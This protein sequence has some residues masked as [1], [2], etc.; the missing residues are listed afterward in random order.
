MRTNLRRKIQTLCAGYLAGPI[1][2]VLASRPGT[3]RWLNRLYGLLT[4]RE[5]RLFHWCFAK[6]F[7]GTERRLEKGEWIVSFVGQ[8]I[9]IPLRGESAWLDWDIAVSMV[10]HDTEIVSTYESL[11][12]ST[13]PP[14][15]FFDIGAN[16]GMHSLLLLAHNVETVSFEPNPHCHGFFERL[17]E[18]NNV[19]CHIEPMALGAWEGSVDLWFPERDTWLGTTV[20]EEAPAA[21]EPLTRLSVSQIT[22]DG[23]VSACGRAPDLI[24]I[25]TEGNEAQILAG[26]RRTLENDRPWVIF[27]SRRGSDRRDLARLFREA[28]YRI[29]SLPILS[30]RRK[31]VLGSA[32]FLDHNTQNFAAIPC[33][34]L[35]A[36]S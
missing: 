24:K 13:R 20:K 8:D 18:Y 36:T 31:T 3:R 22:L 10:G 4:S 30:L 9:R 21:P 34:E 29:C 11:I 2:R 16:Y 6:I 23:Y 35:E 7:R 17:C 15:L 12:K 27:E 1:V 5:R 25:D 28:D 32:Q 26:G 33:E 19:A 14:S